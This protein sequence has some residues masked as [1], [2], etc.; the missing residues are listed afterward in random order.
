MQNTKFVFVIIE[1][2][3]QAGAKIKNKNIQYNK[4]CYYD[5]N[6]SVCVMLQIKITHNN[7]VKCLVIQYNFKPFT[8]NREKQKKC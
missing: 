2:T 1:N 5:A 8:T 6:S 4:Y 7:V 3:L